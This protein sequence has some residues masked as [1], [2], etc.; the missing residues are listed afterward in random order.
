M[1]EQTPSIPQGAP[2]WLEDLR[3]GSN[4]EGF[5]E[6]GNKHSLL[7]VKRSKSHLYVSF[8]NLS[9]VFEEAIDRSPWG[10]KFARDIGVSH[11]GVFA[12]I[13]GWYR[14]AE[15][16]RRFEA[17]AR[18]GFFDNYERVVFAGVSMGGFAA[19]KFASL[20]PGAHVVAINPQST[21]DPSI[22]PWETRYIVGQRQDWTLPL[23]DAAELT[24]NMGRVNLF[25]DPYH[26]LD[27][28]HIER[29]EGP[30]IHKFKC[31][32]SR[33]KTAVFLRKIDALKPV[34]QHA[35]FDEL[36]EKEFYRLYRNRRKLPWY[37][38]SVS[39]YFRNSGREKIADRFDMVF[40][41]RLREKATPNKLAQEI[42]PDTDESRAR[43]VK[44]KPLNVSPAHFSLSKRVI[45]TTMKNEG[46]FMLEW[47]AYNRSIGF[48]DFLIYTN[49]CVDG[50]D[51]IAMRLEELGI[52]KHLPNPSRNKI[53][54]Q[55]SA[56][57][58]SMKQ[59]LVQNAEWLLCADCDEFLNIRVGSGHL[60]DLFSA[61][62]DADA[63]SACW[64]LFGN[65]GR[66]EYHDELIV[67]QFDWACGENNFPNVR[68]AGL[69]TLVKNNDKL[70]RLKVHRPIFKD[71]AENIAWVDGGG[72]T[73]PDAYLDRGWRA[74][75][76][77]THDFVRLHH[78]AVRSVDSFLVKR[79]RGRT[80]HV[81]DDQGLNYWSDMNQNEAQDTSMLSAI[82]ALERELSSLMQDPTLSELHQ[83]ACDWHRDKITNLKQRDGWDEF[84]ETIGK[85]NAAPK[86][87][88][89]DD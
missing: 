30:N 31:W 82:P 33:H 12:H 56:L 77:F 5:F 4:R 39:N 68:T 74:H 60:D 9:N 14:D 47:I 18:D 22:V 81:G 89:V 49:D 66:E 23:N 16:I 62:G 2:L 10:Y 32:F 46:P 85:I 50:T 25:W 84:R 78:Y 43:I 20:V 64:K 27:T 80:N 29:F 54:Y 21:L 67:A 19:L 51:K 88:A 7:F 38:G 79:D 52:A 70:D 8:D 1:A 83:K 73:M 65:S 61:V 75:P 6:K 57:R 53:N 87:V 37:R 45:V 35:I 41:E 76:N 3:P 17:L 24:K 40:R 71:S 69:K 11:L 86:V 13:K 15:L 26:E 42:A 72:K 36:T 63:I 59:P 34:I 44:P 58:H 48:T 55:L 28:R